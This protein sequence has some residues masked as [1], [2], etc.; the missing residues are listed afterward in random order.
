MREGGLDGLSHLQC[1]NF[2]SLSDR[3]SVIVSGSCYHCPYFEEDGRDYNSV[4]SDNT[5]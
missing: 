1:T 4:S 2:L 5:P 3:E